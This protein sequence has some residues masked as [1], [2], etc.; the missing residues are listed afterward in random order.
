MQYHFIFGAYVPSYLLIKINTP[1][2]LTNIKTLEKAD[3][4]VFLHEYIHF[5][6]NITGGFG[7]SHIWSTYDQLRQVISDQQKSG[8]KKLE[9]PVVND[10]TQRL[11]LFIRALQAISGRKYLPEYMDDNTAF[12]ENVSL[13]LDPAFQELNTGSAIRFLN[14]KIADEKGNK[15]DYL[16]GD[17]AVSETMAYLMES[18]Y[19]GESEEINNF[20]YRSCQ[21][22]GEWMETPLLE[23]K[24][25]LFALCDVA[26]LSPY[27]GRMFYQILLEMFRQDFIP[28]S[29][30][31]IY[32]YGI[33]VMYDDGW[34]VWEDF[35][36]AKNGA[37]IVLSE[38]F[39]HQSFKPT[40][41]WF[42]YILES[43]YK[44]RIA[45]PT[46]MLQLYR[47]PDQYEGIWKNIFAQFGTPHLQNLK[48]ERYFNPPLQLN[49][50]KDE[51]EP[52][53]LLAA[54]Q[55]SNT[56][57]FRQNEKD[58]I[59]GLYKCCDRSPNIEVDERCICEPWERAK[60]EN[61]CAYAALW[62][63][64]GLSEKNVIMTD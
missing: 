60:D 7:Q 6:Q 55:V 15:T 31:E 44:E 41:E 57:M 16:F 3:R 45:N 56:L 51:I 54:Q 50:M 43:G 58:T 62:T 38:L 52:L 18:K 64:Y 36:N 53:L 48:N 40:L 22:L 63:G 4:A 34:R 42:K 39:S 21:K 30:E 33:R 1:D 61:S 19:F 24:E 8:E 49:S 37:I 5:L 14:L 23:N 35:E 28:G 59:C 47:E 9:I 2:P 12:I 25:W 46:F 13:L 11:R 26:L 10:V 17:T 32:E 27:P 20:P 29:A